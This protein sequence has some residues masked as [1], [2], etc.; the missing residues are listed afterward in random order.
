LFGLDA[1]LTDQGEVMFNEINVRNQG[2]TEVSGVNQQL[3]GVPPFLAAHLTVL[4]GGRPRWLPHVEEFNAGTIAAAVRPGPGPFYLKLRHH[5]TDPAVLSGLPH[6]PGVYRL[7][8]GRLSWLR[9]GVH[10]ADADADTGEVL[11]ANLPAPHV[12]C[13]PGAELGTAEGI[14]A[15]SAS[16]FA[17]THE[18]SPTGRALLDALGRALT[19]APPNREATP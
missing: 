10:A 7:H 19:P 16:P 3:R 1:I 13:L 18:L 4:L 8:G 11:L 15:G 5:G 14:T 6:G 17:G 12:V 2:T 9:P